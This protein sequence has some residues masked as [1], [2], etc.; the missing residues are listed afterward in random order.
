MDRRCADCRE[1]ISA[2]I[3]GELN[4]DERAWLR[5]HLVAC[6]EC[7]ALLDDYKRVGATVRALPRVQPPA[8]LASAI[9]ARTV[10]TE[11]RRLALFTN[12][13]GYSIG[14]AAAVLLVF[15][16]A[17][18]LLV[19]GYQRSITP[20]VTA[21][22]PSNG[23][24]ITPQTPI[25][26]R[27]NKEMNRASV[28]AALGMLPLGSEV[29]LTKAWDGNTLIIGGN[30]SLTPN[31]DYQITISLDAVD[32]WGNRLGKP[33]ELSFGTIPTVALDV[34]T[35]IVPTPEPTVTPTPERSV[36]TD[37]TPAIDP[38][39][40]TNQPG[41]GGGDPTPTPWTIAPGPTN[42]PLTGDGSDDDGVGSFDATATPTP[43]DDGEPDPSTPSPT[44]T[45]VAEPSATPSPSPTATA[46]QS[47]PTATATAAV[48]PTATVPAATPT[49]EPALTPTPDVIPVTGNIG[50]VY[51]GN[52]SVQQRLGDPTVYASSTTALSLGFQRASMLYREDVGTIYVMTTDSGVFDT[53]PDSS[54]VLPVAEPGPEIDTWIP[55]GIFGYLW[56]A[57]PSFENLVGYAQQP[58]SS[59]HDATVQS[60][61]G[62]FMIVY[63]DTALIFYND[64][65][66]DQLVVVN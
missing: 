53:Y 14:A 50:S 30:K 21:S 55:G 15:V 9:Y 8:Q 63:E 6:E 36:N 48:T 41:V 61:D 12:R 49:T 54:D 26:I 39:I 32:K 16:V 5:N 22:S 2:Y 45:P 10:A 17:G 35:P 66:W 23:E 37:T 46:T 28:E 27:F 42:T 7:R 1:L 29:G 64:G 59:V 51:W 47:A 20:Q 4:T 58:A 57:N 62:G 24:D 56:H 60:F 11:Q 18:Y 25:E 65:T 13:L 3:D 34:P 19:G 38:T 31:A 43:D 33:F 40:G 44:R 52:A